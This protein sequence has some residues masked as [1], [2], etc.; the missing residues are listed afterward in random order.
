[1]HTRKTRGLPEA[2]PGPEELHCPTAP[3]RPRASNP[4]ST[5]SPGRYHHHPLQLVWQVHG[6]RPNTQKHTHSVLIIFCFKVINA[7]TYSFKFCKKKAAVSHLFLEYKLFCNIYDKI[8]TYS[9]LYSTNVEIRE[10]IIHIAH[11]PPGIF[12]VTPGSCFIAQKLLLY[13]NDHT[14]TARCSD[15]ACFFTARA[16]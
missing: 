7:S 5:R 3:R 12:C 10:S 11:N 2:R 15:C 14:P 16:Q 1:M 9:S 6:A 4:R 13:L 8:Y